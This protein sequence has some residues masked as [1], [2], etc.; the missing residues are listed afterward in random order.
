MN[1]PF[2]QPLLPDNFPTASRLQNCRKALPKYISH[3]KCSNDVL[4]L[5]SEME[6]GRAMLLLLHIIP[7]VGTEYETKCRIVPDGSIKP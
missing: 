2:N 4:D 7:C 1:R 5:L 3:P 6:L